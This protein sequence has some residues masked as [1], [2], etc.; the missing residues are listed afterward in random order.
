M[1]GITN[2]TRRTTMKRSIQKTSLSIAAA[3]A[4]SI[5]SSAAGFA[6]E[7]PGYEVKGL[8]ISPVQIGLLGGANVRQSLAAPVAASPHQVS[9]LTSPRQLNTARAAAANAQGGH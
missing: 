6:A 8:P 9:V 1:S 2:P 5:A 7:L 4:I 3:V